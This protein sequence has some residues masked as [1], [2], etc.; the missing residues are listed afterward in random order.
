MSKRA[1]DAALKAY[2]SYVIIA[3]DLEGTQ[4]DLCKFAREA[5][6]EGYEQAEKDLTFSSEDNGPEKWSKRAKEAIK[7]YF[8]NP[9]SKYTEIFVAGYMQA[10]QDLMLTWKDVKAVIAAEGSIYD[11]HHGVAEEVFETYPTE[12]AFYRE[13][14]KRF[15]ERKTN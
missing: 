13:V 11:E 6:V 10:E 12:E 1:E 14:L 7:Y 8:S 4:E 5:Y 3:T 15:N 9:K 2:P